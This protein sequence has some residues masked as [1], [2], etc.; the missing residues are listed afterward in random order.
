MFEIVPR[1]LLAGGRLPAKLL[2]IMLLK[3]SKRPE[4]NLQ[5]DFKIAANATYLY[6][7]INGPVWLL[8][9]N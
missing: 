6:L 1:P 9:R 5:N 3:K 7:L 8:S 4:F 2:A